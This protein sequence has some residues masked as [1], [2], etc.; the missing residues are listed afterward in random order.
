MSVR[1]ACSKRTSNPSP[2][3]SVASFSEAAR[4]MSMKATLDFCCANRRTI[5]SP[6]PEPPPVTRTVLPARSLY[7]AAIRSS[8][9][10]SSA[11]RLI[12]T[13]P[14]PCARRIISPP[15]A[16][17]DGAW[18]CTLPSRDAAPMLPALVHR[19]SRHH[20]QRRGE[21]PR[22]ALPAARQFQRPIGDPVPGLP[23]GPRARVLSSRPL[24]PLERHPERPHAALRRDVGHRQRLPAPRRLLQR[25]HR[26]PARPPRQLR[27]REPSRDPDRARRLHYGDRRPLRGKAAQLPQRRGGAL[28]RLD[29]VHGPGLRHR[30]GL[31]G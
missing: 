5:A 10:Y 11:K 1:S 13:G 22:R 3:S 14:F 9:V 30:F 2:A 31:R 15:P 8:L 23:L 12:F 28:G 19:D 17:R 18:D 6:I 20:D 21:Y 16:G 4:A 25:Q 24:S 27:A 7:V 29:L 26:R